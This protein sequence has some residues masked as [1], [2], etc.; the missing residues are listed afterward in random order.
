MSKTEIPHYRGGNDKRW[1]ESGVCHTVKVNM[2]PHDKDEVGKGRAKSVCRP[3]P[4]KQ[5]CLDYALAHNEDAGVWG[6]VSERERRK[7]LKRRRI[8]Q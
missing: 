7:M 8:N 3:C 2:F 1:M 4:V 6:G 5:P